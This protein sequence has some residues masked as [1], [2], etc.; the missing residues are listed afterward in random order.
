[1]RY[2]HNFVQHLEP[3]ELPTY[4]KLC[5][6]EGQAPD[7]QHLKGLLLEM[8]TVEEIVYVGERENIYA[9]LPDGTRLR[10]WAGIHITE[11]DAEGNPVK[12]TGYGGG[13][14]IP[15]RG[16]DAMSRSELNA[17]GMTE[18]E[19]VEHAKTLL[20]EVYTPEPSGPSDRR[21]S[22]YQKVAEVLFKP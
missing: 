4:S 5:T 3:S 21:R 20:G 17:L 14:G 12:P 10:P 16:P 1:M 19:L 9:E 22:I 7:L 8:A 15:K 18:N 2:P 11:L 6:Y 13:H